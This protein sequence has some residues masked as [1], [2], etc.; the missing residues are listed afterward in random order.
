LKSLME[1]YINDGLEYNL[2]II[3]KTEG[4]SKYTW[5]DPH[6]KLGQTMWLGR[7]Q[8]ETIS[9]NYKYEQLYHCN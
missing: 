1:L 8:S 7:P 2:R 4:V 3:I 9:Y 5:N 6:I